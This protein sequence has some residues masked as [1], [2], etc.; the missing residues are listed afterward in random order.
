M[1]LTHWSLNSELWTAQSDQQESAAT[2]H[3]E[4]DQD[5][6]DENAECKS[7]YLFAGETEGRIS[8]S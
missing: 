4:T 8:V 6:H 1:N 3:E 7:E 5:E 2:D